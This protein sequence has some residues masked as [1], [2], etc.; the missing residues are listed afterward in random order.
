MKVKLD[1][2]ESSRPF[3]LD[4]DELVLTQNLLV[5]ASAF[6][7]LTVAVKVSLVELIDSAEIVVTTGLS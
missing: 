2:Q 7:V 3:T 5:V 6:V 1:K 4:A